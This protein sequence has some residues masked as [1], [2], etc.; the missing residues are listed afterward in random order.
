[1]LG[2]VFFLSFA[3]IQVPLGIVL[4]KFNPLKIIILMLIVIYVG[5]IILIFCK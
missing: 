5:T 2:G 1:M 3:L 4:D